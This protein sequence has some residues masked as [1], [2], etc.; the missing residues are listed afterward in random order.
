M[1]VE[2]ETALFE[3]YIPYLVPDLKELQFSSDENAFLREEQIKK[4]PC[5][6]VNRLDSNPTLVQRYQF[7]DTDSSVLQAY[8]FNQTYVIKIYVEKE[9]EM[10]SRRIKLRELIAKEPYIDFYID[11]T[12]ES[13]GEKISIGLWLQS[14]GVETLASNYDKKG[15][16]RCITINFLTHLVMSWGEEVPII[17]KVIVRMKPQGVKVKVIRELT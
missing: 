2:F 14:I 6:L 16:K 15:A 11:K 10:L 1:I 12:E 8:P 17:K 7:V 13:E 5:V 4:Y 9:Q 3:K